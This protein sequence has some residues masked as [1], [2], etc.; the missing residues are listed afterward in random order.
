MTGL[1][2]I[3]LGSIVL[4]PRL[5]TD[6]LSVMHLHLKAGANSGL[7]RHTRERETF[8]V[9]SGPLHFLLDGT[10]Q[11]AQAG[12][13]VSLPAHVLHRFWNPGPHDAEAVLMLNPGGLAHYFVRLRQ[14]LQEKAA[15]NVLA[16]L[17][18][19]YGLDFSG[20]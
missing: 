3:D 1:D 9:L 16:R 2:V 12:E 7:H 11:V 18:E 13:V 19:E 8:Y 4:T 14:L 20:R 6:D 15:P 10:E 17:N 5:V